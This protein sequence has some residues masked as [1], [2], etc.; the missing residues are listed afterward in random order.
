MEEEGPRVDSLL[1][2]CACVCDC[3]SDW[4]MTRSIGAAAAAPVSLSPLRLSCRL[5]MTVRGKAA[6]WWGLPVVVP[7]V[8]LG[9]LVKAGWMVGASVRY[10]IDESVPRAS[11]NVTIN[12]YHENNSLIKNDLDEQGYLKHMISSK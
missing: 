4:P 5:R 6:C 3:V 11:E 1:D 12:T 9:T 7:A 2:A 10:W 8:Y